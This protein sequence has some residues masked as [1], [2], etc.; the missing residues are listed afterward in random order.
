MSKTLQIKPGVGVGP[1]VL[2]MT[3]DEVREILGEPETV[4]TA[5]HDDGTTTLSW[6]FRDGALEA[7]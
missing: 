2:G 3:Q 4:E 7:A 6:E 1:L 5:K